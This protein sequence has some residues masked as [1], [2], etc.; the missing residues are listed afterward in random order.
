MTLHEFV[1]VSNCP[2]AGA[3]AIIRLFKPYMEFEA[4]DG[5]LFRNWDLASNYE[6]SQAVSQI[7]RTADVL[8]Q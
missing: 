2:I 5:R 6:I 3:G 4:A 7:D 1:G 8:A